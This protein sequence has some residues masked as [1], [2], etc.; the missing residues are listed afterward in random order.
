M[1]RVV[2][3]GAALGGA[4][5]L[6]ALAA[7]VALAQG[8]LLGGK[9]RTGDT[10]TVGA[11]E[12]V[13]GDLYV[14]G[15]TVTVDGSVDGDLTALG[16]Q[17]LLNG[18]VSGD[19]LAAGGTVSISG[20]VAGD[21]R[22]SG[23][24]ITLNGT[25]GED[26]L[27]A[28]GQMTLQGGG[29]IEGDLIVTGG[30]VTVAGTVAGNIEA[31]AGTYSRSGSVGGTEHVVQGDAGEDEEESRGED[32]AESALG[33]FRHF[34][35][36]LLLGALILLLA[37]RFLTGSESTL[38]ARPAASLGFGA[39]AF[40]GYVVFVII[41]LVA[42]VLLGVLLGLLQLGALAAID[43][44]GG[45]LSV[46]VVSFLFVVVAAFVADL[47]VGLSI[48]RLVAREPMPSWWQQ[49]GIL[50]AGV[51][52]VV[53]VT[54]LPIIGGIAKL[55]VILFGLGALVLTARAWWTGRGAA[56][57]PPAVPPAPEPSVPAPGP[58][59]PPPMAAPPG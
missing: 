40:V 46:F 50:A 43:V 28:G 48:A 41:A 4:A 44:V 25:V 37:P 2:R 57:P 39:I 22:S 9:L 21:I 59:A 35:V 34:V 33:A 5:I 23:G 13:D 27:A 56:T 38:S 16:G 52:V 14:L 11:D 31:N 55:L 24:Q 47:V 10:V 42:I 17:V 3:I 49:F 26:V 1:S 6:A 19:V 29:T 54:S 20:D 12:S 32:V 18:I 15:G 8:E 30:Q 51:A 7:S 36:L 45:L 58:S 53:I